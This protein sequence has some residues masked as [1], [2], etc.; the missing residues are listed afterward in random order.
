MHVAKPNRVHAVGNLAGK[1]VGDEPGDDDQGHERDQNK[2]DV[3]T[4]HGDY[5]EVSSEWRARRSNWIPFPSAA[6]SN[7]AN[8]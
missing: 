4:G 2:G 8:R 1:S 7:V 5:P 6:S 3:R